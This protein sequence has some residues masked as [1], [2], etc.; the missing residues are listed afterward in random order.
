MSDCGWED[1]CSGVGGA[2]R[3]AFDS[4]I[5]WKE[6]QQSHKYVANVLKQAINY[7]TTS[8]VELSHDST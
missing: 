6:Y 7:V 2:V 1:W 4:A 3:Y 8:Y 5:N